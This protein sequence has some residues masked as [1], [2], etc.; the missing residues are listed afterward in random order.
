MTKRGLGGLFAVNSFGSAATILVLLITV[1]IYVRQIGDA[2]YGVLSIVWLLVGYFGFL[3]FGLS[4][5]STNALARLGDGSAVERSRVVM[6]SF[7][8]NVAFGL[9]GSAVLYFAGTFLLAKIIAVPSDLVREVA[10]SLPW[11]AALLPLAL[12]SGV[13]VGTLEARERFVAANTLQVVGTIVGQVVPVVCAVHFGPDLSIVIPATVLAR[14][15]GVALMIG[16]VLLYNGPWPSIRIDPRIARGLLG[17][18]GW[19]TISGLVNPILQSIDQ[20]VIGSLLGV[21]SVTYYAIPMNL[22]IRSQ[23]FA[24]ALS[25]T[26]FPRMSRLEE[27]ESRLL[28]ERALVT[29]A[30]GYAAI[31]APAIV[32]I[33]PFLALWI[34]PAFGEAGGRVAEVLMLGTWINGL[35]LIPYNLL[36]AQGR[37][38]VVAKLHLLEALPYLA[39]LFLLT[40]H[41]GVVGA[42]VAW[43]MRVA[44]DAGLLSW[45]ARL[46]RSVVIRMAPAAASLAAAFLLAVSNPLPFWPAMAAATVIG[47]AVVGL[48]LVFDPQARAI[49]LKGRATFRRA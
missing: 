17:Y 15:A 28:S 5:A 43:S 29:L 32:V 9:V 48:A 40:S 19:V 11:M 25:R 36:Q 21:A 35:A 4:R 20:M 22:V 33:K 2:R 30:F 41:Y 45:T 3:D 26:L 38:D 1:P 18:G 14:A 47:L 34:G 23:L 39:V 46:D 42:A 37:P 13:A 7:A 49:L 8:L 6:T 31:C 16:Y 27:A 24:S 10:A 44:L 12:V